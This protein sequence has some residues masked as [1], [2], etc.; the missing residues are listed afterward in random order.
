MIT[1]YFDIMMQ[2][3]YSPDCTGS[4]L[5]SVAQARNEARKIIAEL[6]FDELPS[7]NSGEDF[8]LRVVSEYGDQV[9]NIWIH[10]DLAVCH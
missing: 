7:H 4:T 9:E 2:G 1:Y 5:I 3:S 10:Y 8:T 6:L